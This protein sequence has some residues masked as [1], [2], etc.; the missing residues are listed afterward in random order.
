[1]RQVDIS[2]P[3]AITI[4]HFCP[5]TSLPV[6]LKRTHAKREESKKR[7]NEAVGMRPPSP[8]LAGHQEVRE[9]QKQAAGES[10]VVCFCGSRTS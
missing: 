6:E 4:Q 9:P 10:C 7:R 8:A 1:M 3:S 5:W 2:F